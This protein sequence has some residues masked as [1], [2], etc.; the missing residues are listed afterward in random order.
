MT[1]NAALDS[2]R[3]AAR[4]L[5][6]GPLRAALS[7]AGLCDAGAA[8]AAA[9]APKSAGAARATD[10]AGGGVSSVRARL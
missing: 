2:G 6:E 1:M 4:E 9:G 8:G 10:G 7:G 5:V 3:R